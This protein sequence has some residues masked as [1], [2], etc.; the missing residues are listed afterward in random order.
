VWLLDSSAL[1]NIK[2]IVPGAEQWRLFRRLEVLVENGNLAF[3]K[4][5]KVE[6]TE[7]AH[8]DAPGVWAAGVFGKTKHPTEPDPLYLSQVMSSDAAAVVDPNKT[9]EDGD[10][11]LIALAMQLID[12]GLDVCIVTDDQKDNPTRIAMAAACDHLHVSWCGVEEFFAELGAQ[13]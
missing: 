13:S 7:I 4:Q 5:I 8:P 6:V 3:P 2:I 12:E 10:P 9:R 11:Y 1:T